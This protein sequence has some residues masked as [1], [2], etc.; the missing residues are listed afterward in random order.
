MVASTKISGGRTRQKQRTRRDILQAA[1]QL[2][3]RGGKPTLETIAAEAGVSRATVYRYFS[4][5]DL[6]LAEAPLDVQVLTPEEVLA[7]L[8]A[9]TAADAADRAARVHDYLFDLVAGNEARFRLYLKATLDQWLQAGGKPPGPLRAARRLALF[10]AALAP[11][12]RRLDRRDYTR[13]RHALSMV[14]SIEAFVALIDVC[15][16]SRRQARK[17][18]SWSARALVSAALAEATRAKRRSGKS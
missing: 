13:L 14:V 10:D 2:L 5:L 9:V 16:L 4:N 12:R 15:G 7:G 3:G 18:G 17:T 1:E 8:P 6:L 11:I